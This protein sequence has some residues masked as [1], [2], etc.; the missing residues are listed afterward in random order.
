MDREK[1]LAAFDR[2]L[3]QDARPLAATDRVEREGQVIRYLGDGWTCVLWSGLDETTADAGIAGQVAYFTSL[4]RA[5]EWKLYAYDRPADLPSRLCAAG[6]VPGEEETLMVAEISDLD[7]EVTLPEGVRLHPVT[8]AAD[9]DLMMSVHDRAFGVSADLG[10]ALLAQLDRG[11][12]VAFVAMAGDEP[13]SAARMELYPDTEFAGLWSGGTVP[14]WR[15]RGLYRALVARRAR[16]AADSGYRYLQV[17]ASADSRPI[18]ER[19][20]FHPLTTTTP[21]TYEP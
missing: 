17:D 1:A 8:T 19:L 16:V 5:F 2:A 15:G 20:G 14:G 7:T 18:L 12:L 11:G 10:P 9:V 6:F 4:G 3:R 21:Y 13:V